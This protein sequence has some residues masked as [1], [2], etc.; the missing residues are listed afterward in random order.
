MNKLFNKEV[1]NTCIY[2]SSQI[3]NKDKEIGNQIDSKEIGI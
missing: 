2:V 3:Y 1:E